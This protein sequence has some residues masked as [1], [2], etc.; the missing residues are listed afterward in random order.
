MIFRYLYS[1]INA[2]PFSFSIFNPAV[3]LLMT[4]VV[5]IAEL[6]KA[7]RRRSSR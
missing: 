7:A 6:I 4:G 1:Q 5:I 3:I 2:M